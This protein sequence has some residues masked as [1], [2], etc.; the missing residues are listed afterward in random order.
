MQHKT[1]YIQEE[2]EICCLFKKFG[3]GGKLVS[4]SSDAVRGA[5]FEAILKKNALYDDIFCQRASSFMN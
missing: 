2:L 5:A 4:R 1:E 3:P